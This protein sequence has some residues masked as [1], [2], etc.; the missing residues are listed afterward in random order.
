MKLPKGIRLVVALGAVVVLAAA[1][2]ATAGL[3]SDDSALKDASS[4]PAATVVAGGLG[5]APAGS[6]VLVRAVDPAA[7]RADGRLYE[8]TADGQARRAGR[9]ACK[10]VHANGDGDGLCLKLAP[11]AIDYDGVIFGG[12]YRP[13]ARFPIDGVPDRARVSPDGRYGGY[14]SFDSAGSQGYFESSGEFVT[15]TRIL[16]M[17]TGRV[18][19]RLEDLTVSRNGGK[20]DTVSPQFWGL[21]FPGGDR[22]YA[23]LASDDRH[24]LIAGRVGSTRARVVRTHVECP[25]LSPDGERIAYKRR[26]PGTNRWRLHVLDLPTGEDVELAETRSID[27]Q[28]E[29]LGDDTI[30]YSDDKA[31][32]TVPADGSGSPRRAAA[33]AT[34]P[35]YLAP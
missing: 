20:L 16:D 14:T 22:Y 23:T 24:Y 13:Q 28:P 15:F 33:H 3:G 32:L 27:D 5:D 6:R 26:I 21:T 19:L 11:N 7:P 29:W 8:L 31:V 10:R 4:P 1:Y 18:L 25:S 30:V 34:S 12:D 35:V 17:R 9:L 2:A